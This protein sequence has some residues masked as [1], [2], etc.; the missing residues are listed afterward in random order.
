MRLCQDFSLHQSLPLMLEQLL[1]YFTP[2]AIA[3]DKASWENQ[4]AKY[5]I[6]S[7]GIVFVIAFP[8]SFLYFAF[9]LTTVG[10]LALASSGVSVCSLLLLRFKAN[11]R[12]SMAVMLWGLFSILSGTVLVTGGVHS[13][14]I[15]S[16]YAPAIFGLLFFSRKVMLQVFALVS[17]YLIVLILS[18]WRGISFSTSFSPGMQGVWQGTIAISLLMGVI[19]AFYFS[20][21]IRNEALL[22]MQRERDSVQE[23]VLDATQAL[24][25]QQADISRINAS[26]EAQNIQLHE[27]IAEAENAK[28]VQSDFLRNVSHEVR[29]PLSAVLGFAEI[30]QDHTSPDDKASKEF[31]AQIHIAGQNLLDMFN[32]ILA[33]ATIEATGAEVAYELGHLPTILQDLERLFQRQALQKGLACSFHWSKECEAPLQ[34][35]AHHVREIL[36]YLLVNAIKFTEQGSVTVRAEFTTMPNNTEI[37]SLR[38]SVSDTGIGIDSEYLPYLFTSFRQQDAGKNRRFGGLGL[39]LAIVKKLV[40]AMHGTIRCESALHQGTT[41]IVDIPQGK[42]RKK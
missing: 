24:H 39:G 14:F 18:D 10:L 27:A 35:D 16:L 1:A 15:F 23:K 29:T 33:L 28:Q 11:L 9:G 17:I 7:A 21:L 40:D 20:D 36:R 42:I 41:F 37:A 2:A 22:A 5:V 6:I 34:I 19:G 31:I 38:L 30:L 32:N 26:L 25:E 3:A 8:F 13:P 4:R 12:L